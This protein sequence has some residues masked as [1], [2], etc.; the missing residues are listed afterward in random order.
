MKPVIIFILM[1]SV[2]CK[3]QSPI[4]PLEQWDGNVVLNSYVKDVNNKLDLFAGTY[5]T[6]AN[7]KMWK[8]VFV[9]KMQMF[10]GNYYED[11]LVGEYEYE[12]IS[13]VVNTLPNLAQSFPNPYQ[14]SLVGNL[15]VPNHGYPTCDDCTPNELRL[16]IMMKPEWNPQEYLG[17]LIIRRVIVNGQEAIKIRKLG[18]TSVSYWIPDGEY[19]LIKQ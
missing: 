7:G 6:N 19:I 17:T 15:L 1:L 3:A 10:N 18:E 4:I 2:A 5:V 13:A 14:H 8:I 16:S 12:D 11:I 9:K